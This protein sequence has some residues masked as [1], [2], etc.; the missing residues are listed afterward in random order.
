MRSTLAGSRTALMSIKPRFVEM[1]F[2]GEKTVELRRVRPKLGIG[3]RVLVYASAPTCALVGEF[4]VAG[5]VEGSPNS[6]WRRVRGKAGVTKTDYRFYFSGAPRAV[7]I[8]ISSQRI[9][10]KEPTLDEL[11]SRF[12]RFHPPQSYRY[13][14]SPLL[15]DILNL[16]H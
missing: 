7:A 6:I 11:R 12:S 14:E 2:S 9:Y 4:I 1:I 13:L 10:D 15:D 3:D 16:V 8:Q 5:I